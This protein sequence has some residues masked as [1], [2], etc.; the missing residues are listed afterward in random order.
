[1][2]QVRVADDQSGPAWPLP[3]DMLIGSAAGT[4]A[5]AGA[6]AAEHSVRVGPTAANKLLVVA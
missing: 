1:M 2:M 3:K 4:V 5:V 6:Q